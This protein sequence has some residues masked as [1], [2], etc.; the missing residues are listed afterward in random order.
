MKLS[1]CL[2]RIVLYACLFLHS[3][4][5]FALDVP[6][7]KGPVNDYA[8]LFTES[9]LQKLNTFLYSIDQNNAL[10]IAVLTVPS[11]QGESI[12]DYSIRVAEQWK[13]G[14]KG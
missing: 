7:L 4:F 5:L 10:Q 6:P 1:T 2:F 11:L 12:E 13:I 14:E 8:Q 3:P 9:E